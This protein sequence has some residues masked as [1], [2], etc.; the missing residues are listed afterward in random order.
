M[1]TKSTTRPTQFVKNH[2]VRTTDSHL[3]PLFH[4]FKLSFFIL[5]L[6]SLFNGQTFAGEGPQ[7]VYV[8]VDFT[9]ST[10]FTAPGGTDSYEEL[11]N[12]EIDRLKP[13][14]SILIGEITD[15]SEGRFSEIA[16]A[17][18]PT[19][20]IFTD[21]TRKF[22]L[23]IK[24][25]KDDLRT[26]VKVAFQKRRQG[27]G[28]AQNTDLFGSL[29]LAG[30]YLSAKDQANKNRELIVLSDMCEESDLYNFKRKSLT[31]KYIHEIL[32]S[33]SRSGLANLGGV[34][35][36]ISG[37]SAD[38]RTAQER[39]SKFWIEYFEKCGALIEPSHVVPLLRK[40]DLPV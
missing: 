25:E 22:N 19:E 35:V 40:E 21:T 37:I 30:T 4:L 39:L 24:Q 29:V 7:A 27:I 26:K 2:G 14:D 8:L 34:K 9:A 10:T 20:N 33:E 38:C 17:R 16:E 3:V 11:L 32:Q 23:R 18:I 13:G 12:A 1:N 36:F 31:D 5:F 15:N 28:V 6:S